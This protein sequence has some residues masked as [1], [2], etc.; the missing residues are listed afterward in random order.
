MDTQININCDLNNPLINCMVNNLIFQFT[1]KHHREP[2]HRELLSIQLQIV[3]EM[4]TCFESHYRA[5]TN[6][7][8]L[9][10]LYILKTSILTEML[11]L[12]QP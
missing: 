4:I 7:P 9:Q 11:I 12:T 1:M 3:D 5:P 6:N 8:L 2:N 10:N